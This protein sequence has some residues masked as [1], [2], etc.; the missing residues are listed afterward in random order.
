MLSIVNTNNTRY[1]L[2]IVPLAIWDSS[3]NDTKALTILPCEAVIG[4]RGALT[5]S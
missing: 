2:V 4:P 3:M 5:I 1:K